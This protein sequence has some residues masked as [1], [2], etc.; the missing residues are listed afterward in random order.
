MKYF[1]NFILL[2]ASL[3]AN[4]ER[5]EYSSTY[6]GLQVGYSR[7][8][9]AMDLYGEPL[10]VKKIQ[11]NTKYLYQG[12]DINFTDGIPTI[13]SIAIYDRTY[14]DVNHLR[15][16]MS[17]SAVEDTFSVVIQ[18]D[19]FVDRAN[20]IIYWF[21]DNLVSTIALAAELNF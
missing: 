5:I 3:S 17:K 4:A 15:V 7:L 6:Q 9:H 16:G 10:D 8:S 21:R 13:M 11:N 14:V 2:I 18:N 19:Y 20:G 12:F 1:I